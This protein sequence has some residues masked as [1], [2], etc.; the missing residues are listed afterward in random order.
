MQTATRSARRARCYARVA[1]GPA[2][3]GQPVPDGPLFAHGLVAGQYVAPFGEF[4]FP[5]NKLIGDPILPD[6]FECLPFLLLGSGPLVTTV[7]TGG[8][9]VGPLDPWPDVGLAPG[10]VSCGVRPKPV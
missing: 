1:D 5:E 2:L 4:I 9:L 3:D 7:Q 8:P 10:A 6:N